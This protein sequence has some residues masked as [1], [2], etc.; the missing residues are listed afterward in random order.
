LLVTGVVIVGLTADLGGLVGQS[1][2]LGLKISFFFGIVPAMILIGSTLYSG[3]V[4]F[5]LYM[6]G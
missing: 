3:W 4:L 1:F 2:V 5:D 6:Y